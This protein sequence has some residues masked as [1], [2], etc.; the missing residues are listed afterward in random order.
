[1]TKASLIDK[2]LIL[3]SNSSVRK[4]IIIIKFNE[5]VTTIF[6]IKKSFT[7]NA[8]TLHI[9]RTLTPTTLA[10]LTITIS[11]SNINV[12]LT[13]TIFRK[14]RPQFKFTNKTKANIYMKDCV[15]ENI[16]FFIIDR[17]KS[18]FG[19]YL[20]VG[21]KIL[22]A[23]VTIN[24]NQCNFGGSL[25]ELCYK[26]NCDIDIKRTNFSNSVLFII[27]GIKTKVSVVNSIFQQSQFNH[28]VSIYCP[29]QLIIQNVS[30]NGSCAIHSA[31]LTFSNC[32]DATIKYC[33]FEN[34]NTGS[35]R[36]YKSNVSL[37]GS[38]FTN[39]KQPNYLAEASVAYFSGSSVS[40][41]ECH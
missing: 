18:T 38:T 36:A 33:N 35:L 20:N 2:E 4:A 26:Y 24:V 7:L 25:V 37:I 30:F 31:Q 9:N 40:I 12:T 10:T 15:V 8:V 34:S 39:N 11:A 17:I 28:D 21:E 23:G 14:L 22:S 41:K 1:M 27:S 32:D 3:S 16:P 13:D 19:S 6:N 29:G 5:V